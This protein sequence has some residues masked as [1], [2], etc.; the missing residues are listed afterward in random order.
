MGAAV[1]ACA[2]LTHKSR[3]SFAITSFMKIILLVSCC[4][5][6]H[7]LSPRFLHGSHAACAGPACHEADKK[8][9]SFKFVFEQDQDLKSRSF[10]ALH[11]LPRR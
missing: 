1:R 3:G 6:E 11:Q 5:S 2:Y 7:F 9:L 10:L 4:S 8:P